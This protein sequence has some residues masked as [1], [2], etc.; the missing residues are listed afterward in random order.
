MLPDVFKNSAAGNAVMSCCPLI[1]R[2][3]RA[4]VEAQ[5]VVVETCCVTCSSTST[6]SIEYRT[7]V[8]LHVQP[9]MRG[10]GVSACLSF[11]D[12]TSETDTYESAAT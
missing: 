10:L 1:E 8:A 2:W 9:C 6:Q 12:N 3:H 4:M 7:C 5:P 11:E